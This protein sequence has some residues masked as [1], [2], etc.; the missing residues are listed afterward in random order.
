[1]LGELSCV[2]S[3]NITGVAKSCYFHQILNDSHAALA[4]DGRRNIDVDAQM[5]SHEGPNRLVISSPNL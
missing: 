2:H 5:T 4:K 1:M 3:S